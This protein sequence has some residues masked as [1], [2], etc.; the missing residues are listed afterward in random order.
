MALGWHAPCGRQVS[1][2]VD[3]VSSSLAGSEL[4]ISLGEE[5]I[6]TH[7]LYHP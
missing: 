3:R 7:T 6:C 2:Y 4:F 5:T 1:A